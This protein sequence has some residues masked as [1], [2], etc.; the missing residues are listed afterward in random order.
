MSDDIR[1]GLIREAVFELLHYP[2]RSLG[3]HTKRVIKLCLGRGAEP[4][5]KINWHTGLVANSLMEYYKR[6]RNAEDAGEVLTAVK[7]YFDRW[8]AGGC[9]L[10][11]ID[12]TLCGLALI[13]L[14]QVTGDDKYKQALDT[15]AQYLYH[16]ETDRT[17]SLPYRPAQGNGHIYADGI[18]M[19]CPFLSKYGSVYGDRN[20]INLAVT[21][22]KN[23]ITYGMDGKTGLPYHG[24]EQESQVKYGII[25]WGR[26]VGFLMMGMI[27]CLTCL[28]KEH[29]SY[30][31]IKQAF[32]RLVDKVESYQLNGGLYT[33]QL[34]TREG[35]VDTSATG[36]IIY[37]IAKGLQE[38]ILI[39]IHKSRMIRGKEGLW[40]AVKEGKIYGCLA[41]CQG[42]GMYPQIYGAYPWSLGPAL[43]VFVMLEETV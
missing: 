35:S 4:L 20:A 16:H 9:K 34:E 30:E 28:E 15:M 10:Y 31:V 11:Y 33:W 25:G 24:Y 17:G 14:H 27:G 40:D 19:M 39:G 26:A 37:A 32:R 2:K 6:N 29:T 23:F 38:E 22:I 18:G 5:D 7:K 12:D 41:E 8:I 13:D 42:F 1:K 36:M 43:G 3:W 21:Q